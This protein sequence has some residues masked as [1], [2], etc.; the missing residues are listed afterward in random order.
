MHY[1]NETGPGDYD[2][3]KLTGVNISTSNVRNAPK[4]SF[5]SKILKS[6]IISKKHVQDSIGADSPGVGLYNTLTSK[7]GSLQYSMGKD[8]RFYNPTSVISMKK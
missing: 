8:K 6:G 7:R 5:G 4:F 2:I 3:K 1:L